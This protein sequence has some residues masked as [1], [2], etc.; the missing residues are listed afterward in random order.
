M[1]DKIECNFEDWDDTQQPVV[2]V[3]KL[4][5]DFDLNN[6]C[7]FTNDVTKCSSF[8]SKAVDIKNC[9]VTQ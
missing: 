3:C 2:C 8:K 5:D 1:T 7:G 4:V 6:H 9:E